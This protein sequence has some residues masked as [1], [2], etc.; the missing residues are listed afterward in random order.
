MII[1]SSGL[2]SG[3]GWVVHSSI[4][5]FLFLGIYTHTHTHVGGGHILMGPSGLA[6]QAGLPPGRLVWSSHSHSV[7]ALAWGTLL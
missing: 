1:H 2:G 4:G 3:V 5:V 6:D 7:H